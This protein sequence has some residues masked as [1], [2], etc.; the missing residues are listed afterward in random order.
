MCVLATFKATFKVWTG[1]ALI[2]ELHW[3]GFAS[4]LTHGVVIR[5][6][7]LQANETEG[8][9][10]LLG[11]GQET[12]NSLLYGLLYRAANSMEACFSRAHR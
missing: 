11:A 3:G 12:L 1:A 10:S 2:F 7:S 4:K 8:L 6:L 5:I 9:T